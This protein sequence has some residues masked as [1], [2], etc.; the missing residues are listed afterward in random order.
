MTLLVQSFEFLSSFVEFNLG[1][2][3]FGYFLLELP[4]FVTDFN[5]KFFNL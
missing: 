3:S 1:G 2:L 4:T 5:G